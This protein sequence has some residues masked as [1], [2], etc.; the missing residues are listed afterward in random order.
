[1]PSSFLIFFSLIRG[2]KVL[3]SFLIL[4]IFG[5]FHVTFEENLLNVCFLYERF[6]RFWKIA[7][8]VWIEQ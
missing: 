3:T 5:Y 1:M 8:S 4:A 6:L 2:L 7:L